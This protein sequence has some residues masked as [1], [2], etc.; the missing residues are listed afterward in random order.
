MNANDLLK[1]LQRFLFSYRTT[2]Q[3]T[4]G[5]SPAELLMG[6]RLVT[7]F[8]LLKS[9]VGRKVRRAQNKMVEQGGSRKV[10]F[11]QGDRV[12]VLG[13]GRGKWVSGVVESILGPV[14]F[15]IRLEDGKF[16]KRHAN[17]MRHKYDT[18]YPVDE[19]ELSGEGQC[20]DQITPDYLP[21]VVNLTH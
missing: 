4:T 12:I 2:P 9:E 14:T 16:V 5:Q 3:T 7:A 13:F 10:E 20:N 1:S 19:T 6:R 8:D 17:Q 18:D 11:R 15:Q 21:P